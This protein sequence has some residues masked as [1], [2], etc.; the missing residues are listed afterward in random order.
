M[1][2]KIQRFDAA[3]T[4]PFN[5]KSKHALVE[6]QSGEWVKFEDYQHLQSQLTEANNEN[7][8]LL[9]SING[10]GGFRARQNSDRSA[11]SREKKHVERLSAEVEELQN[12]IINARAVL[13]EWAIHNPPQTLKRVNK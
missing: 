11:I 13:T 3:L 7:R 10:I 6:N 8:E 2:K 1:N 9:E 12:Q 4:D 5:P